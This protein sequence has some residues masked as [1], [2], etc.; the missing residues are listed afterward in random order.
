M[1]L[2]TLTLQGIGPFAGR[3]TVDFAA[4]SAGGLF[5]LEGPT[6]AGKS[7]L[8]DAIVF[9]LYGKVAA[10]DA[11][12]DRL[13][14]A[15]AGE[16][17]ES[18]VD[19]CFET[20]HGVYRV[21]RT[22]AY[23]RAKKRGSGTVRQNATVKLW[24]LTAVPDDPR[25]EPV[26][27]ILSTRL[28]EAGAELTAIIG[29]DRT[30]FVQTMVLPQGEFAGFLRAEPEQRRM[31]LQR[32][33]GTEVYDRLERRLD[34][35]RKVAQ[36]QV[37]AG[38]TAVQGAVD[39]FTGAAGVDDET[40]AV[41]REL[42]TE[43]IGR[44]V[45]QVD[46]ALE[47]VRGLAG[48]S[49]EAAAVAAEQAEQAAT[50]AE[51]AAERVRR[52][53]RWSGLIAEREL[54]DGLADQAAHDRDRLGLAQRSSAV[55]PLI[56]GWDQARERAIGAAKELTAASDGVPSQVR[57]ALPGDGLTAVRDRARAA[58][59]TL[60]RL[61]EVESGLERRSTAV[62]RARVE[63]DTHRATLADIDLRLATRPEERLALVRELDAVTEQAHGLAAAE[64][65]ARGAVEI[66]DAV[67]A[68]AE[69]TTERERIAADRTT[70]AQAALIAS[71]RESTLRLTRLRGMAGE[72][73]AELQDGEPCRVCGSTTHPSPQPLA[74]DHVT[75]DQVTTAEQVRALAEQHLREVE[76]TLSALDSRAESLAERTGG[77]DM[78]AA[79]QQ[80]VTATEAVDRARAAQVEQQRCAD[81]VQEHDRAT[82]ALRTQRETAAGTLATAVQTADQMAADLERDRGEV[83]QALGSHPTVSAR[84]SA[85]QAVADA[86]DAVLSARAAVQES[87]RGAA[88]WRGRAW[89]ALV[90]HGFAAGRADG[91]DPVR[92][93]LVPDDLVSGDLVPDDQV[94]N[95]ADV[96]RAGA[97]GVEALATLEAT[98]R[99][100]QTAV[101]R[102]AT[103]LADP[104]LAGIDAAPVDLEH[105][106]ELLAAVRAAATEQR[107]LADEAAGVAAADR[108][109]VTDAA[110]AAEQVRDAADRAG[111][112]LRSAAPVTRM[113]RLAAG[114]DG[115]QGLSLGTYVLQR[116]FEDVVAAAN[117]RL[118]QMSDGRFELATSEERES[119]GRRLGLALRVI[120]HR[121]GDTRNPRT[122]S[123]GETFYVSLCLALGLADVVTAEAGGIELGTLFIDEGFGSLDPHTL[124]AVLT[125]LGHL[126]AGGRVVGLVSHVEAMKSAIAE[127][128]AV[129]RREDGSSDLRVIAG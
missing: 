99:A 35:A 83:T 3:H 47:D 52:V 59:A 27:E 38:R 45:E 60:A 22:P 115:G 86:A 56:A 5:L 41:L 105:D 104:D 20:T 73:A 126:R 116:R 43:D 87:E 79:E 2:H 69:L 50:T 93:D 40:A 113:A 128:I 117:D 110:S 1:R 108:R 4:L 107:R 54:L 25:A 64:Q 51:R 72:L 94:H 71:E 127:R 17:T 82:E 98:V 91:V 28:D 10:K 19:L 76:S 85:E 39:R 106:R 46:A 103:G 32:I 9:A 37:A 18:L 121:S 34:E 55:A 119:R 11:S 101:D 61:V 23:D 33:F 120:D 13:R 75:A 63:V 77:L 81:R 74:D 92:E 122:L 80:V 7:T 57:D 70:A 15:F 125:E 88:D 129:R 96:A 78:P 95:A 14:S 66:R 124:D 89:E 109:R 65:A 49:A 8:I 111:D 16:D 44:A 48:I 62:Q 84:Q 68:L 100:R 42:V 114:Q 6:G 12:E 24:R 36:D 53:E 58:V 118:R 30:Q 67:R 102:V 90:E 29:L 31:L 21:R 26:G 112:L 123:G 97:L